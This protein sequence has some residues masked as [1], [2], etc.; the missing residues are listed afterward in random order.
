[1]RKFLLP[2]A[3]AL[4]LCGAATALIATTAHAEQASARK[5]V[6]LAQAGPP[7]GQEMERERQPSCGDITT[8]KQEEMRWLES[9][10]ALTGA[11]APLFARW[12]Q[13][14]LDIA[15][16]NQ[17]ECTAYQRNAGRTPSLLD[18]I[19]EEETMLRGRLA[20]LQT[21]RPALEAFYRSLSPSQRN[22]LEQPGGQ[23]SPPPQR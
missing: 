10:L 5:P 4:M 8:D 19:A 1:M 23:D 16:R 18:S 13:V 3:A 6:L 14:A 20:D 15:R 11:Q 17:S 2:P 21:E 22:Q 7:R 9:R 12:R